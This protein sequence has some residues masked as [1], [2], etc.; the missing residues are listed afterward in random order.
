MSHNAQLELRKRQC[1]AHLRRQMHELFRVFGFLRL[2]EAEQIRFWDAFPG[3][4]KKKEEFWKGF[5]K[6]WR[7]GRSQREALEIHIEDLWL[8]INPRKVWPESAP[9]APK[10]FPWWLRWLHPFFRTKRGEGS[11]PL[12]PRA[13]AP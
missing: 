8:S 7:K 3:N 11:P 6:F 4:Q 5:L 10:S 2:N 13:T 9:E 1:P 12:A